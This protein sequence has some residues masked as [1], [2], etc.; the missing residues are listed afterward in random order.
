MKLR[1]LFLSAFCVLSM[2]VLLTACTDAD[3]EPWKEGSKVELPRNR[4]FILNEGSMGYNNSNLICFDWLHQGSSFITESC[5]FTQQN[6]KQLGDTGNDIITVDDKLAVAVNGSNYVALLSGAGL[7]LSRVSFADGVDGKAVQVRNLAYVDKAL[8]VTTYGGLVLKIRVNGNVLEFNGDYVD[9][10]ANLE[11]ICEEGGK[12]YAVVA[13]AYPNNDQRVAVIPTNN[14]KTDAITYAEVMYNPDN[15]LAVDGHVFVQ[16]YGP[17]YDYPFGELDTAT[18][19]Y[20]L[21]GTATAMGAHDGKL[22]LAYSLTDW[23]TYATVTS[24]SM[25]DISTGETNNR[26]FKNVPEEITNAFVYSISVNPY[27]GC[28]Y[29]A[30]SDYVNNGRVYVFASNGAYSGITFSSNGLNPNKIVFLK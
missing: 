24:L 16:G 28:I 13:G 29:V 3:E 15:I 4:A 5:I 14:F 21:K 8:Y 22:Y 30:T 20:Y 9:A 11:G 26:F 7:E 18:N 6:D 12:L 19:T 2:G 23:T 27:D 1:S 17:Y 25:Y 10:G